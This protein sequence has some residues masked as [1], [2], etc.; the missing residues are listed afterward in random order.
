MK[1]FLLNLYTLIFANSFFAKLNYTLYI[2]SLKGMGVL[3]YES[4]TVSGEKNFIKSITSRFKAPVILDVGGN[5]G[6]YAALCKS[7]AGDAKI[8]SFEPH[9]KTYERLSARAKKLD[10]Q[11]INAAVS[12]VHEQ[13]I[14][15]DIAGRE[16]TSHAS[17][18]SN[19]VSDLRSSEVVEFKV[20]AIPLDDYLSK[21]GIGHVN[22][23]KIDAEGHELKILHGV[24]NHIRDNK[25]DVIHFEFNEMNII[26]KTFMKDFYELLSNYLFYRLLPNGL[27]SLG[28]YKPA[29]YEIFLFQNIVA[30]RKGIKL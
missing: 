14:L 22:L 29:R 5:E 12:N 20:P 6:D 1:T 9:P 13:V 23:L 27:L 28:D 26:S 25:I 15:Y 16:G 21:N 3:N 17:L 8:Y 19:A 10:F 2:L 30:L 4:S 11:V 18:Y 7:F 24:I